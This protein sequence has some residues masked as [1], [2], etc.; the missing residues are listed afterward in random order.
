M[1]STFSSHPY[2]KTFDSKDINPNFDKAEDA[3]NINDEDW[4]GLEND[5]DNGTTQVQSDLP[6]DGSDEEAGCGSI[7]WVTEMLNFGCLALPPL[8]PAQVDMD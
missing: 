1:L 4:E 7:E 6:V 8:P 2:I 3:D 5:N